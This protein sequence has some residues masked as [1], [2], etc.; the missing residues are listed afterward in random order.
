V[1]GLSE[2]SGN[3]MVGYMDVF[4][5]VANPAADN[6]IIYDNVR[7]EELPESDCNGN[8][9]TDAC[10]TIDPGDF[11]GDGTVSLDDFAGLIDCLAGPETAPTPAQSTCADWC[12]EAFDFDDDLDVDLNDVRAFQAAFDG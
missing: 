8:G 10:E 11:D 3:V 7:V 12:L 2:T 9:V 1:N 4:A 5:S 6:F